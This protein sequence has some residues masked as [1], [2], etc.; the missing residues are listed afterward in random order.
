MTVR[1]YYDNAYKFLDQF[2]T[3]TGMHIRGDCIDSKRDPFMR[4][5]PELLDIG[6]MGGCRSCRV[7][8]VDCYQG[9]KPYDPNKDMRLDNYKAI[10][11]EG[12][13]R[14]LF[15]VALGGAGNPNDHAYFGEILAYTRS[16]G[17]VPNYTTS[18]IGLSDQSVELTARYV[19]AVAVSWYHQ[20]FTVDAINK[21]LQA[22]VKTSIHYVVSNESIDDAINLLTNHRLK[23]VSNGEDQWFD[24]EATNINAVIFLL[25]KPVGLGTVTKIL[26][27]SDNRLKDFFNKVSDNHPFKVGFDSC[28]VPAILN[29]SKDIE[30]S[31][32]DTCE[33]GR[34]SAY[35]SA[36]MMMT[37]CSFDQSLKYGVD[38]STSSIED[39]WNSDK[40]SEFRRKLFCSC[41]GCSNRTDCYGGCPLNR[42][43]VLCDSV[44]NIPV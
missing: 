39:A 28:S 40:F 37:P 6:I 41:L 25:Y 14:G 36:N 31:S 1:R 42:D 21:F 26:C 18:G 7:C 10:I 8:G 23:Y 33:G 2:D 4:S 32:I 34:F 35:I 19:G 44:S 3:S 38:L 9:G 11:D 15:Q 24:L 43:I 12:S 17:V 27:T 20:Q 13:Q 30:K 16:K 5:F 29:Y 22:N